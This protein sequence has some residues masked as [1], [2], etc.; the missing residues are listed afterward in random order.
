MN[1]RRRVANKS[2]IDVSSIFMEVRFD[3]FHRIGRCALDR[4]KR[5]EKKSTQ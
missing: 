3:I 5:R 4:A 1:E 2:L